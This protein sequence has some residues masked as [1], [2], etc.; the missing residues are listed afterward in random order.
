M[1]LEHDHFG[2]LETGGPG[3]VY[4]SETVEFGDQ[5]VSVS[6][7]AEDAESVT[8]EALDTA[9][10]MINSLEELDLR[11]REAM[12]AEISSGDSAVNA[13]IALHVEEQGED[14]E[15]YFTHV[16]GDRDID[17][18]R[19]IQVIGVRFSPV[20]TGEDDAF[21]VFD[22][23]LSIDESDDILVVSLNNRGESVAIEQD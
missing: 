19:S 7:S 9:A 16:S 22:Y 2:L 1:S 13:F 5:A 15:D 10:A 18:L 11:A 23:A 8:E 4:W 14:L 12:I 3:G 21:V 17:F 20:G 6:L